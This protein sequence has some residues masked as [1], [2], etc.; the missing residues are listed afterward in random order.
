MRFSIIIPVHNAR[1]RIDTIINRLQEQTFTDFETIYV[2]D[3][4]DDGSFEYI[5]HAHEGAKVIE[6]NH[7]NDGL[8]RSTGLDAAKGDWVMFIDDD[9]DWN[10]NH[11]LEDIDKFINRIGEVHADVICCG[12]NWHNVGQKKP[13]TPDG[14]IWSNVW[15]KIWKRSFIGEERFLNVYPDADAKFTFK[16]FDKKPKL[17]I[18]DYSFY[19]YNYLREG[20][21]SWKERK[22]KK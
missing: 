21:I 8:A 3:A 20:S 18:W 17:C 16:M 9:D 12:F 13:L 10:S 1:N 2:V 7:G 19:E 15:S 4:S 6:T 22:P 14:G 11:V 5:C